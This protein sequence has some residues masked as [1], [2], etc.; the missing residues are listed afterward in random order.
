MKDD[1]Y[2]HYMT[3]DCD[4]SVCAGQRQAAAAEDRPSRKAA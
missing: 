1:A 4:C 2:E 3:Y